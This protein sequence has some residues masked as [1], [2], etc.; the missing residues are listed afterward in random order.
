MCFHTSNFS[1]F[2]LLSLLDFVDDVIPAI[3]RSF[4]IKAY[5]EKQITLVCTY[6]GHNPN[7]R[8]H[9]YFFLPVLINAKNL[10]KLI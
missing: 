5:K 3:N 8:C 7:A 6:D 10:T 2:H 9:I 4:V 1:D